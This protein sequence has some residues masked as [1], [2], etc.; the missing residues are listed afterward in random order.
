MKLP[1]RPSAG[2]SLRVAKETK[3]CALA[4]AAS[5]VLSACGGGSPPEVSETLTLKSP[6][7]SRGEAIPKQHTCDGADQPPPLRWSNEAGS[8]QFV[9]TVTDPTAENFVHWVV[10]G[11]P[12]SVTSLR[13]DLPAEAAEGQNDFEE[14]GYRGPCPPKEDRWHTYEF[15]VYGISG[16]DTSELD[17]EATLEDVLGAVECCIDTKGTLTG[18]YER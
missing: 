4:L 11:L 2:Y 9:I 16:A 15:S 14:N 7:F 3:P 13:G 12:G 10:W 8:K 17:E 1:G 18:T 5:L 6:A